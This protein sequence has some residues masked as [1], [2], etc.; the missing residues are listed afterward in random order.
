MRSSTAHYRHVLRTKHVLS[1]QHSWCGRCRLS[2]CTLSA[3]YF[4]ASLISPPQ[5]I[6]FNLG[7]ETSKTISWMEAGKVSHKYRNRP[8]SVNF[9]QPP[10]MSF[11]RCCFIMSAFLITCL[12][13]Q[14]EISERV[15]S[16]VMSLCLGG[17]LFTTTSA[18]GVQSCG[19]CW[20]C[21]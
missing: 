9:A 19:P 12:C 14:G 4:D 2:R 16:F 8:R 7:H 1:R 15:K 3:K 5:A 10:K 13:P 21:S 20:G 11:D 6:I 17:N 18:V